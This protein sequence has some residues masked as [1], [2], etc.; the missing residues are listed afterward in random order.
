MSTQRARARFG[1]FRVATWLDLEGG[2][3]LSRRSVVALCI[4][5]CTKPAFPIVG[6]LKS[7]LAPKAPVF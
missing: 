4:G 5:V 6:A 7:S 1:Q 3:N 2:A